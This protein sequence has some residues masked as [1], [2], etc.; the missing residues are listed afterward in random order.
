MPD[1]SSIWAS[2]NPFLEHL[3]ESQ[4]EKSGGSDQ[5][6]VKNISTFEYDP[7]KVVMDQ[8]HIED[9]WRKTAPVEW[10]LDAYIMDN[11]PE[12]IATVN[13]VDEPPS[14][15]DYEIFFNSLSEDDES[16][17]L[18]KPFVESF[19]FLRKFINNNMF[20]KDPKL[21]I[22]DASYIFVDDFGFLITSEIYLVQMVSIFLFFFFY[23]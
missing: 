22:K 18:H 23:Y 7:D 11:S 6:S 12:Y 14:K 20:R 8:A 4:V 13:S 10:Q 1:K 17:Q 9:I 2:K 3:K 5:S 16:E 15:A 21:V 19:L